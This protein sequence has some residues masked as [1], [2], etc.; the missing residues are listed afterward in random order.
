[1][2]EA[3]TPDPEEFLRLYFETL[4]SEY[5][6][7]ELMED[8]Q[9]IFDEVLYGAVALMKG[10]FGTAMSSGKALREE[11]A[12]ASTSEDPSL[13]HLWGHPLCSPLYASVS[14]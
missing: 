1:M 12:P 7:L 5:P 14:A 2:R 11:L 3:D 6:H 13:G 10:N 8:R 9:K 4:P